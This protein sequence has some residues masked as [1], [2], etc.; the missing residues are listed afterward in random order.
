MVS[1]KPIF[2]KGHNTLET[3]IKHI[4]KE[5]S[6]DKGNKK[7]TSTKVFSLLTLLATTSLWASDPDA[8]M[9]KAT[10]QENPAL[11]TPYTSI[12]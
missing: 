10:P 6:N 3:K 9:K 4:E 2:S 12:K 8:P 5:K 1:L 7:N 11:T